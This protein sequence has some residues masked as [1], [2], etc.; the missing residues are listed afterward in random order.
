MQLVVKQWPERRD[1][2]PRKETHKENHPG[3][4]Q[5]ARRY[6]GQREQSKAVGTIVHQQLPET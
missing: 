4:L 2:H 3:E 1:D 6:A 5:Q